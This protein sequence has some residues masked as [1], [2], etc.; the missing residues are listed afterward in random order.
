MSMSN[1]NALPES[2]RHP[3]KLRGLLLLIL[4]I[5]YPLLAWWLFEHPNRAGTT[6][7]WLGGLPQAAC[8]LGLLWL[9]GR[10]LISGRVALITRFA[11][12]FHGEISQAVERYTRQV[13]ILWC[14]FFSG[15]L[16]VDFTLFTFVSTDAW[17]FFANVLNLPFLI[18]TFIAEFV[19][20][21]FRFPD[22][23][24]PSLGATV[25]AFRRFYGTYKEQ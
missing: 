18:G 2:K 21:S 11:R 1:S 3:S 23:P 10:S 24:Y 5:G 7:L 6:V 25:A 15:M 8:Y 19:Y 22:W 20:R 14:V 13:T 17:L 4:L 12:F 16:I 9:F